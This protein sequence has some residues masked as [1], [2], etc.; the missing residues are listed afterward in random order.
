MKIVHVITAAVL[1]LSLAGC[2]NDSESVVAQA[3]AQTITSRKTEQSAEPNA[4]VKAALTQIAAIPFGSSQT[5]TI[6]GAVTTEEIK[7]LRDA[8]KARDSGSVNVTLNFSGA[9]FPGNTVPTDSLSNANNNLAEVILPSTVTKIEDWA[10]CGNG[11][12]SN[13]TI[14]ASVKEI[15]VCAFAWTALTTLWI[16]D[17]VKTLNSTFEGCWNLQ[18]VA[19]PAS[20]TEFKDFYDAN[21]SGG[22]VTR[23]LF[24][25]SYI[26]DI[27]YL[28]TA[29][30][31]NSI[32]KDPKWSNGV[33][34]AVHFMTSTSVNVYDAQSSDIND[35][36][37][38]HSATT[39][40]EKIYA[41]STIP[42]TTYKVQWC[43]GYNSTHGALGWYTN[44]P[45]GLTD[46][47]IA[48][49]G[50]GY[51]DDDANITFTANANTT[52][53]L[54]RTFDSSGKCAFRV[55]K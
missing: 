33:S 27:Y 43:D 25:N 46:C 10:F 45:A 40:S 23:G 6:T 42:G 53:I 12:L 52:Y 39:D 34:P 28:G 22:A 35:G 29:S 2:A 18:F 41:I 21:A 51:Y 55:S 17:G 3:A 5:V 32:S 20:V 8:L 1:A 49:L 26:Q 37:T 44:I 4:S 48:I 31:W 15:G 16:P 11:G 24:Q 14:P 36:Y 50:F 13:I 54:C 38:V 47:R 7:S 9:T 19:I 30:Q